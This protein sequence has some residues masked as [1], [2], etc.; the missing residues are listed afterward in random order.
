MTTADAT[1]ARVTG[2]PSL[3]LARF[4]AES[5]RGLAVASLI[6]G[7]YF[8]LGSLLLVATSA[9]AGAVAAIFT[10]LI[11]LYLVVVAVLGLSRAA[12]RVRAFEATYGRDAGKQQPVT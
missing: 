10:G 5:G 1:P 11:G 4:Q 9:G 12:A 2:A 7:L 6:L 8:L 3:T